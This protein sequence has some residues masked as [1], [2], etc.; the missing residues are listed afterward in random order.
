MLTAGGLAG[1]LAGWLAGCL[2]RIWN[3]HVD[4]YS[5]HR[6]S[7][8]SEALLL[9]LAGAVVYQEVLLE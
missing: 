4:A 9:I 6:L 7:V 8:D 1:W 5:L 2:G 3:T